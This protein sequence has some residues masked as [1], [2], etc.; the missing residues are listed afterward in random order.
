MRLKPSLLASAAFVT[1]AALA[2]VGAS[3]AATVIENRSVEAVQSR[4]TAAGLTFVEVHADGLQV[5]LRGTAPNEA[6]R[7]RAVNLA[8][9]PSMPR[10]CA[11]RSR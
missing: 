5:W 9:G 3:V 4:L 2:V 10:G 6:T 8:G 11:T 1:A 7:F